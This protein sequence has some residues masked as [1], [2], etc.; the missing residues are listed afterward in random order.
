MTS[1]DSDNNHAGARVWGWLRSKMIPLAGLLM[2]IAIMGFIFYFYWRDPAMFRELK[3][4]GYLGAFIISIILNA[5]IILPVSNMAVMMSLGA[6]LHEPVIL[7]VTLYA[8]VVVGLVGGFGAAIGELTG[9]VAGRSG[10]GLL[11]KA[12]MYNRIE[13][14]VRR[15][16]WLAIFVFSVIPFVFDLVGIAAGVLRMPLWKFFIPCWLGRTLLYVVMVT[17]AALGLKTIIPWLS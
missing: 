5:S 2:A 9:Y 14:W 3:A 11:S 17:L 6:T 7:G 4:Y 15:W 12:Q 1:I 13:G 10:R 8:P 16:G